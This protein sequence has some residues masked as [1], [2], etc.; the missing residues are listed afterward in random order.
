VAPAITDIDVVAVAPELPLSETIQPAD[1]GPK[2]SVDSAIT[3]PAIS[4]DAAPGMALACADSA[5][6]EVAPTL[7]PAEKITTIIPAMLTVGPFEAVSVTAVSA[8]GATADTVP[9][10]APPLPA[11]KSKKR[12]KKAENL[13]LG[14]E[15]RKRKPRRKSAKESGALWA[16]EAMEC[17]N[18][19][20]GD[21]Q[22]GTSGADVPP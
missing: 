4:V 16:A 7:V 6:I 19:L 1:I 22:P 20:R 3:A 12:G 9:A 2:V 11:V 10:G 8:I 15:V 17:Q 5:S 14:I 18:G 21:D 13:G